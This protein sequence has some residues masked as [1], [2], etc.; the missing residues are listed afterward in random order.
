[1]H[2]YGYVLPEGG[3]FFNIKL[4][5]YVSSTECTCL[6]AARWQHQDNARYPETTSG[7]A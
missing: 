1:M 4:Q 5:K 2:H 7:K 6:F 3:V